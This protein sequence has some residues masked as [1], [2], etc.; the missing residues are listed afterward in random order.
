MYDTLVR[1]ERADATKL[2]DSEI[3]LAVQSP[4]FQ[5][6]YQ[7]VLA[8]FCSKPESAKNVAC[9]TVRFI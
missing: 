9:R 5:I 6:E 8:N 7:K 2:S 4:R 1:T 3:Q